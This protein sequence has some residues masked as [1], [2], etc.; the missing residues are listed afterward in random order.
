MV[1]A[2]RYGLGEAPLG[3]I[4]AIAELRDCLPITGNLA[5]CQPAAELDFGDWREGRFAWQLENIAPL[6]MPV[7]ISGRQGLWNW[8][9]ERL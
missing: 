3:F 5:A 7:P 4:V 9:D 8:K 1:L 6:E 2:Q